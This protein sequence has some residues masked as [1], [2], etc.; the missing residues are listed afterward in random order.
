[1]NHIIRQTFAWQRK[2]MLDHILLLTKIGTLQIQF[3]VII[4]NFGSH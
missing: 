2:F 4:Y 3:L 1:M